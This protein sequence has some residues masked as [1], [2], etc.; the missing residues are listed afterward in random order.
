MTNLIGGVGKI[1]YEYQSKT[2][3]VPVEG[4]SIDTSYGKSEGSTD[5]SLFANE[6][7]ASASNNVNF[8]GI[9]SSNKTSESA[10]VDGINGTNTVSGSHQVSESKGAQAGMVSRLDA[11]D[12]G[13][14]NKPTMKSQVE[15]YDNGLCNELEF[16]A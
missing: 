9:T 1:P 8:L 7:A 15:G 4:S 5:T 13:S 2:G 11:Y 12:G 6:G 3:S 10:H 14:L 16:W